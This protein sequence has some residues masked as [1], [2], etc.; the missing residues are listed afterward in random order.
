MLQ[1]RNKK[2]HVIGL[3]EDMQLQQDLNTM[4]PSR[5][6]SNAKTLM[7]LGACVKT[8]TSGA[9]LTYKKKAKQALK[10]LSV[11]QKIICSNMYRRAVIDGVCDLQLENNDLPTK[12]YLKEQS[13]IA[14]AKLKEIGIFIFATQTY[15][16][17][18][19]FLP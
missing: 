15:F 14:N 8:N 6:E 1:M 11:A 10:L 4:E 2:E 12:L 18:L 16:V 19:E 3:H 5:F 17:Q 13:D 7:H 9:G